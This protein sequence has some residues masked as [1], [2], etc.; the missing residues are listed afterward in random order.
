[1]RRT[2]RRSGKRSAQGGLK[3]ASASS[4]GVAGYL[5]EPGLMVSRPIRRSELPLPEPLQ[6][7]RQILPNSQ[8]L[9]TPPESTTLCWSSAS[10][11]PSSDCAAPASLSYRSLRTPGNRHFS[12]SKGRPCTE[13]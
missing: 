12:P 5:S 10:E 7:V 9:V 13:E 11:I 1:M 3:P 6:Q 2:T 8:R 4:V